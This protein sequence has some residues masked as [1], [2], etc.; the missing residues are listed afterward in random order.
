MTQISEKSI[1][2]F[3]EMFATEQA[4]PRQVSIMTGIGGMKMINRAMEKDSLL[5]RAKDLKKARK[6]TRDEHK[7]ILKMIASP[8]D[9]SYELAKCILNAKEGI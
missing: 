1:R 9:E 8:D 5:R 3:M 4:K 6:F 2:D 7:T